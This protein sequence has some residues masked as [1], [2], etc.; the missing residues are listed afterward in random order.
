MTTPAP[1]ILITGVMASG[2]ST[3]AQYLAER[4]PRSIHLRGDLFRRMVVGGRVE[5]SADPAPEALSQLRLRYAA[6]CQV[7][8]LYADA[9]F[10]VIYQ[11]TIIGPVLAEVVALFRG[12]PLHVVVLCP[13]PQVVAERERQRAKSGYTRFTVAGLQ[14][15]L[16][17][18]PR[19][20]A[21]I[22]NSAQSVA[23]SAAAV[24][25]CL[26]QARIR[27]PAA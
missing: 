3:L 10:E 4:R 26:E 15:V 27:W 16:Q 2:K 5:M 11:D 9:G 14:Q 23:E 6:A 7:A 18:T 25:Q 20:G 13:R 21:W 1:T 22:D 17:S 24:E 19:V 8:R 12:R